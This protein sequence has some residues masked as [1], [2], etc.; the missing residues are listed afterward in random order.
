M[1]TMPPQHSS[2]GRARH[3]SRGPV[4]SN[5]APQC[6]YPDDGTI[7]PQLLSVQAVPDS[8]PQQVAF[9]TSYP[10]PVSSASPASYPTPAPSAWDYANEDSFQ[11]ANPQIQYATAPGA[12]SFVEG[13]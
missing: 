12:A 8:Y 6:W 3:G 11:G 9:A 2:H 13:Y 4:P 10:P 5:P 7:D 1:A